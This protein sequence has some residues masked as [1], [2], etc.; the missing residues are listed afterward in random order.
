[1][2]VKSSIMARPGVG[3]CPALVQCKICRCPTPGTDKEGKCP[4]EA[5]GEGWA[6]LELLTDALPPV[7]PQ[8]SEFTPQDGKTLV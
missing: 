6:Q 4:A 2:R 5:R 7:S 8:N 1:M 3:K